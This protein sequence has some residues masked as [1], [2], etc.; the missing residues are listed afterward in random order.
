MEITK[1]LKQG[2]FYSINKQTKNKENE[3]LNVSE[4]ID[5]IRDTEDS[6]NEKK[7]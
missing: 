6:K 4:L 7:I 1:L 5:N 2:G 3:K